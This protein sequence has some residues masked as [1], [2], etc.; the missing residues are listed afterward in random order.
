MEKASA[1]LDERITANDLRHTFANELYQ[2]IGNLEKVRDALGLSSIKGA[3]VYAQI[4]LMPHVGK[5]SD[6]KS[7]I[8]DMDTTCIEGTLL[9]LDDVT[10]HVAVVVQILS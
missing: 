1:I 2:R 4:E 9:M 5:E 8:P 6:V 10:P 3:Q 7:P